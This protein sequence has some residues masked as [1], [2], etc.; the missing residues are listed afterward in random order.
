[1]NGIVL[2]GLAE[3]LHELITIDEN[4]YNLGKIG[5]NGV[6]HNPC[7]MNMMVADLFIQN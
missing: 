6:V 2:N 1:M 3:G 4:S 7:I 5:T